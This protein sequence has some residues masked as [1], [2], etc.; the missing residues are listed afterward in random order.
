V[1]AL[2][3]PGAGTAGGWKFVDGALRDGDRLFEGERWV[4]GDAGAAAAQD[5]DRLLAELRALY[6]ADY[7][8]EWRYYVW[9][10][11]LVPP[12]SALDAARMLGVVSGAQSPLLAA[13]SVAARHTMVDSA[14][15][16]AF[17]P[18]HAVTPGA[19][20]TL[21]SPTN[22]PYLRALAQLQVALE[23]VASDTWANG[24]AAG[25]SRD[26]LQ[27]A[28]TQART[29]VHQLTATFAVDPAAAVTG[30]YVARLLMAPVEAAQAASAGTPAASAAGVL[31]YLDALLQPEDVTAAD[32]AR[33]LRQISAVLPRLR[34]ADD[35]IRAQLLQFQAYA[36][37]DDLARGCALL[38]SLR[39]RLQT[40][41]QRALVRLWSEQLCAR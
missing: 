9:G 33:V 8:T 22:E 39:P 34:T 41:N 19:A 21:V 6:R 24:A 2:D 32:A 31:D 35:S 23:Q 25:R 16:G 38:Q 29:A 7:V 28:F 18:V 4:V 13:L 30:R 40:E 37:V 27:A 10:L 36:H 12:G 26:A 15:M 1:A 11:T 20:P 17:Q 5:R 3:V 14:V